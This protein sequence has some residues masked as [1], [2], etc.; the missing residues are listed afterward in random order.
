MVTLRRKLGRIWR[1]IRPH[2]VDLDSELV[3][4]DLETSSLDPKTASLLSI[5]AVPIRGRRI[6]LSENFSRTVCS[7]A[8]VDREAV[9]FHRMRP[10][11]VARGD[12]AENAVVDFVAWLDGRPLIAYCVGFDTAVIDR[13]LH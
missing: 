7:T 10:V 13:V 12:S 8:P 1:T 5:G 6:F 2:E 4:F 3:A 9:K 11:D